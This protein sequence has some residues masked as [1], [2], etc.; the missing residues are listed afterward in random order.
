[1]VMWF[2]KNIELNN[3]SIFVMKLKCYLLRCYAVKRKINSFFAASMF[4]TITFVGFSSFQTSDQAA[5]GEKVVICHNG[6]SIEASINALPAHLA[7]GDQ[8]GDCVGTYPDGGAGV[9][10]A[11]DLH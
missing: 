6:H 10:T 8:V 2:R 3:L 9:K 7:H 4:A 5:A 1:L 11:C